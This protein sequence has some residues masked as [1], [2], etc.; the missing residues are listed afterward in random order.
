MKIKQTVQERMAFIESR[1]FWEKQIGRKEIMDAFYV[2][3]P[4]ATLEFKKYRELAPNNVE[5]NV[6]LKCYVPT[7]IF[8]PKFYK[9]EAL[10]YLSN[11]SQYEE[12]GEM[13]NSAFGKP[14]NHET[15]MILK[16][17]IDVEILRDI[18]WAMNRGNKILVKYQGMERLDAEDRWIAPKNL[19]F[20]GIR[21]DV[22]AFCY[23]RNEYRTFTLS[24]ILKVLNS[25]SITETIPE[26]SEWAEEIDVIIIPNPNRNEAQ[27]A[28][29]ANEHEMVQKEKPIKIRKSFLPYFLL[30]NRL[31]PLDD[32]GNITIKNKTE[33]MAAIKGKPID[34][35]R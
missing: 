19:F 2:S 8:K 30:A 28:I 33:I 3:K 4:Q 20:D 10:S 12:G 34:K 26:D 6:S 15:V 11:L 24:R 18:T 16:N 21:W 14:P 32:G 7:K 23:L 1:L 13:F 27:Q 17:R 29:I 25:T 9:P 5:F 35:F 22:R 31:Y